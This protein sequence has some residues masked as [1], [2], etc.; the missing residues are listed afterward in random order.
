[1]P[2]LITSDL[3]TKWLTQELF[4]NTLFLRRPMC[5]SYTSSSRASASRGG[6]SG[7]DGAS[8]KISFYQ[9]DRSIV[10]K[11]GDRLVRLK[12]PSI[13]FAYRSLSKSSCCPGVT[14]TSTPTLIELPDFI[15][16]L[17]LVGKLN[18]IAA[19]IQK[20]RFSLFN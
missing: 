17:Y 4:A 1:M 10:I 16:I 9:S 18:I 12:R 5:P 7:G 8:K 20:A 3:L 6:G 13:S 19:L 2:R 11:L 14:V 15:Q